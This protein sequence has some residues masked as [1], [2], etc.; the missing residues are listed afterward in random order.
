MEL[1]YIVVCLILFCHLSTNETDNCIYRMWARF[2]H[3]LF[4]AQRIV[5]I[6]R[7]NEI[8]AKAKL[9]KTTI[10]F[11]RFFFCYSFGWV[12]SMRCQAKLK[13]PLEVSVAAIMVAT[14]P[15]PVLAQYSTPW[16][17]LYFETNILNGSVWYMR[18]GWIIEEH[19]QTHMDRIATMK[20]TDDTCTYVRC[21]RCNEMEERFRAQKVGAVALACTPAFLAIHILL[22]IVQFTCAVRFIRTSGAYSIDLTI[23]ASRDCIGGGHQHLYKNTWM[24]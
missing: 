21:A 13:T 8:I 11:V 15:G 12:L 17:I 1:P 10:D 6:Q 23:T 24:K 22:Y 2:F 9:S 7:F 14:V 5:I 16:P 18:F 20:H 4:L 19:V 3:L